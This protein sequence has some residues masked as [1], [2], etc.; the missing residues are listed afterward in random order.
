MAYGSSHARG[1]I[2][3]T[4]VQMP[5]YTTATAAWDLQPTPQL[6]AMPHP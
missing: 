6:T 2:R 3:A 1:G 4:D 5:A